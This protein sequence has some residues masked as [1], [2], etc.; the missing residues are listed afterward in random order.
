MKH[1]SKIT[2]VL[3]LVLT[4][5]QTNAQEANQSSFTLQQ[6][7]EYALKNSPG[8][9]S[10]QL[11]VENAEYRRKEITGLGLPQVNGSFDYKKYLNIPI[12]VIPTEAFGGPP[13]T[14]TT[15]Q[16]G[17]PYNATAGLEASQ[18]IFSSDYIFGLKAAKEYMNLS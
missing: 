18:L 15:V 8:Y 3:L 11:D 10:A 1:L 17:V 4:M 6:A 12:S 2:L 9:K 16:F 7:V 14:Y 5:Y 13:G